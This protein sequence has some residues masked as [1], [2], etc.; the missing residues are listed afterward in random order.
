MQIRETDEKEPVLT[1][2][3]GGDFTYRASALLLDA[4]CIEV[5]RYMNVPG[6]S[7]E[8]DEGGFGITHG[9][10]TKIVA[11]VAGCLL[12]HYQRVRLE[13]LTAVSSCSPVAS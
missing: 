6:N 12:D 7:P 8:P 3:L 10:W 11:D 13:T 1:G 4:A 2:F 5:W 9:P